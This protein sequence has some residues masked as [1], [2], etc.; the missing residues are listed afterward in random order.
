[1]SCSP[2]FWRLAITINV[3]RHHYHADIELYRTVSIYNSLKKIIVV[4][5]FRGEALVPEPPT[6][7]RVTTLRT[8]RQSGCEWIRTANGV[9]LVVGKQPRTWS[10]VDFYCL[11]MTNRRTFSI[12][13][14]LMIRLIIVT[15]TYMIFLNSIKIGITLVVIF[16]SKSLKVLDMA[17]RHFLDTY[18]P[19]FR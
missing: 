6:P 15:R 11:R 17:K 12:W 19:I 13:S 5:N 7:S 16:V 9:T 10:G 2:G 18:N 3:L 8:M 4:W 14:P 1:M